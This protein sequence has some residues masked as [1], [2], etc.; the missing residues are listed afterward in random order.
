VNFCVNCQHV[1]LFEKIT[2]KNKTSR[3]QE[4]QIYF[5]LLELLIIIGVIAI[6]ATV[7][8]HNVTSFRKSDDE[9][10]VTKE[11]QNIQIAA[12]GYYTTYDQQ[13][14]NNNNLPAFSGFYNG[15]I[16]AISYFDT[17]GIGVGKGLTQIV[18]R[19]N[20]PKPWPYTIEF[21]LFCTIFQTTKKG[22]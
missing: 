22:S 14:P 4:F 16:R 20:I 6:L 2:K 9:A 5:S 15:C 13:W 1:F 12:N 8:I 3:N 17:Y 10:A 21:Y 18:E 7:I 11:L 19:S